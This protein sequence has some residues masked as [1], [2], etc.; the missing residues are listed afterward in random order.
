MAWCPTCTADRPLT[1]QVLTGACSYCDAATNAA[2][3]SWCR[4]P[5][6]GVLDACQFCHSPIFAKAPDAE[7]YAA[8]AET[9]QQCLAGK[10][11]AL[12]ARL[13]ASEMDPT[14]AFIV[15]VVAVLTFAIIVAVKSGGIG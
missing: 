4:G 15:L 10:R 14:T 2:H 11:A 6:P 7:R 8:V 3:D 9:E 1:R 13:K 12:A 5:V